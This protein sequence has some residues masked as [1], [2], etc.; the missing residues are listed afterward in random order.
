MKLKLI[1]GIIACISILVVVKFVGDKVFWSNNPLLK[2]SVEAK[3]KTAELGHLA[4]AAKYLEEFYR[5]PTGHLLWGAL[6]D[7]CLKRYSLQNSSAFR[8]AC[9]SEILTCLEDYLLKSKKPLYLKDKMEIRL[10]PE[11]NHWSGSKFFDVSYPYSEISRDH[12]QKIHLLKLQSL[13]G[14][15]LEISLTSNCQ[16]S[17]LDQ[18]FYAIGSEPVDKSLEL[19]FDT[20][21]K[22]IFLD[23][24]QVRVGEIMDWS[25]KTNKYKVEKQ[26]LTAEDQF[27]SFTYLPKKL[28][29]E[30]CLDHGKQIMLSHFYDA[31][32]FI[33][34][35]IK[36][37]E[38]SVFPRGK[39]YW[40]KKN[41]ESWVSQYLSSS[42]AEMIDDKNCSLLYAK[43]CSD[44]NI[45]TKNALVPTWSGI[46]QVMGGAFEYLRNVIVPEEN[47]R[48]SS[49]YF[50]LNSK[51]QQIGERGSWDGS[52]FEIKNFTFEKYE[53]LTNLVNETQVEVAFRCYRQSI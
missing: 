17:F 4:E 33:P 8:L 40:V 31:A 26:N 9:S 30:Y 45:S 22:K 6:G 34:F 18:R 37:K 14:E 19:K 52:G 50:S 32:S 51:H 15:T 7:Q 5:D 48:S 25:W 10:A 46:Y 13:S 49:K 21:E 24:F 35:D 12:N 42:K 36:N 1:Y 29:H 2:D 27:N 28:M 43:E 11:F 23:A 3:S 39:Y 16:E 47:L 41:T 53:Q 38:P 44:K 20:Y